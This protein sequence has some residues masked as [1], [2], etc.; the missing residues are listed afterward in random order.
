MDR[1]RSWI[2]GYFSGKRFTPE[3]TEAYQA[4][5]EALRK[6]IGHRL[7]LVAHQVLSGEGSTE[8]I[9]CAVDESTA[10]DLLKETVSRLKMSP[11][12]RLKDLED[13]VRHVKDG[14]SENIWGVLGLPPAGSFAF[15]LWNSAGEEER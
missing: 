14:L 5:M 8:L 11:G 1:L 10:M 9:G 6:W 12:F 4:F 13:L 2:R 15:Q 3:Q 7:D